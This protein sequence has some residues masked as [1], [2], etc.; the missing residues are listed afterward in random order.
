MRM[1]SE[2][3]RQ[4]CQKIKRRIGKAS[5][6]KGETE[7]GYLCAQFASKIKV[8]NKVIIVFI[9]DLFSESILS[10]CHQITHG[11]MNTLGINKHRGSLRKNVI[12]WE[13]ACK[14]IF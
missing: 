5:V 13:L 10:L 14:A 4:A 11:Q 8:F 7:K 2:K 6:R 1:W 9:C 12:C 3:T